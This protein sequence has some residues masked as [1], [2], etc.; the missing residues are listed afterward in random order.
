M[1]L[2]YGIDLSNY[3]NYIL[4]KNVLTNSYKLDIAYMVKY[5]QEFKLVLIIDQIRLQFVLHIN[6]G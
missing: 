5:T 3:T 6:E 1:V 4:G 2:C